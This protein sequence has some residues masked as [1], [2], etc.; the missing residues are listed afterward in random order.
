MGPLLYLSG[1][2]EKRPL[3]LVMY[4][5]YD[6]VKIG[7]TK[8]WNIISAANVL[9]MLPLIIMYFCCQKYFIE[10]ISVSGIKQ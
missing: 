3:A 7:D 10:G 9:T 8:Q 1:V 4:Q 5:M 6:T 2:P